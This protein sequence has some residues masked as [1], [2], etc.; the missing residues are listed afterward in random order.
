M[1][2][3]LNISKDAE[4]IALQIWRWNKKPRENETAAII[5]SCHSKRL[6]NLH[7][8]VRVDALFRQQLQHKQFKTQLTPLPL[9]G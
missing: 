9:V 4:I 2:L 8:I 1:Y 5:T 7:A 3:F 6:K